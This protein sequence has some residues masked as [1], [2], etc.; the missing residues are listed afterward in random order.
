LDIYYSKEKK[1]K[2]F[3]GFKI[4]YDPYYVRRSKNGKPAIVISIESIQTKKKTKF[5]R[6]ILST[7]LPIFLM[8]TI[9]PLMVWC[10]RDRNLKFWYLMG[11]SRIKR[12]NKPGLIGREM[13]RLINYV[14]FYI[15]IHNAFRIFK[16]D[17][18]YLNINMYEFATKYRNNKIDYVIENMKDQPLA[19]HG[20]WQK[21]KK[22]GFDFS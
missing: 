2:I 13:F 3:K 17:E 8:I 1:V 7:I 21:L 10:I 18:F 11:E 6:Y 12:K 20:S 19:I 5:Q 9:I 16:S 22:P 14:L 15:G 4:P